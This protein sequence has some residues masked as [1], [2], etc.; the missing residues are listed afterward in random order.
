MVDKIK[1]IVDNVILD[2]TILEEK[3]FESKY[4]NKKGNVTYIFRNNVTEED[5]IQE[6]DSEDSNANKYRKYLYI[7]YIVL[8]EPKKLPNVEYEIRTELTIHRNIR[9]DWFGEGSSKDLG[10]KNFVGVIKK[11]ADLFGV[12]EKKIWNARVTK[13]ELGVTL[14]LSSKMKGILSCFDSFKG[15]TEK[16]IYGE[17]GIGFI[18][19][20]FS[21]SIYD[22]L[23]R[24]ID[25]NEIFKKSKNKKRLL[26]KISKNHY[27]L[28]FELK[29]EKVSGFYRS[30]FKNRI[31]HLKEIRDNWNFLGK[32]VLKLYSDINY[33]DLISPEVQDTIKGQER[34]PM[35]KFLKFTG[36]KMIGAD[37]F[38]NQILPL[39]KDE[40]SSLSKFRKEY[41][42][43]YN[44]YERVTKFGYKDDFNAILEKK[45]EKLIS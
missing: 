4:P 9:K 1:F 31:N 13:V 33:I 45:I 39:M 16:N 29:I 5:D 23:I 17:N 6:D 2:K 44:D 25:N 35:D 3:F 26:K 21:I 43:F 41:R 38:F 22:K 14:K 12:E 7:K 15:I 18:G 30:D 42:D 34:K 19:E 27:F 10:S 32:A 24:L 20:N 40:G 8:R 11:Y 36:M 28:R 37:K